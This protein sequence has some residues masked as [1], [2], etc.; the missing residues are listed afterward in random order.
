MTGKVGLRNRFQLK[1]FYIYMAYG[2]GGPLLIIS[3]AFLIDSY[4]SLLPIGYRPG[5]GINS[6]FLHC[7]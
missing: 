5:V 1:L 6:C 4:D 2:Y 7:I 3:I